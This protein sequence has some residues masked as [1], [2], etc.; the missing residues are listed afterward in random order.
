MKTQ[1]TNNK[2]INSFFFR[3]LDINL[4]LFKQKLETKES[5]QGIN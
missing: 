5:T 2:Y 3:C 1:K 4:D